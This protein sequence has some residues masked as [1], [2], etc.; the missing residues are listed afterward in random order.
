MTEK[1]KN[2]LKNTPQIN[3]GLSLVSWGKGQVEEKEKIVRISI[4]NP[5]NSKI[6]A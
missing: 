2:E 3:R 5:S 4:F 1:V 6:I